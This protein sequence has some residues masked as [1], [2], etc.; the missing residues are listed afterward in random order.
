MSKKADISCAGCGEPWQL[1]YLHDNLECKEGPFCDECMQ[2][3]RVDC[4]TCDREW[5]ESRQADWAHEDRML[6]AHEAAAVRIGTDLTRAIS[7]L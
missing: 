7:K 6:D 1:F 2:N 4:E 5:E 3:H